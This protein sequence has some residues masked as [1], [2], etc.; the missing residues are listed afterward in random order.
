MDFNKFMDGV[1][2]VMDFVNG[3]PQGT[4]DIYL[5]TENSAA[6]AKKDAILRADLLFKAEKMIENEKDPDKKRLMEIRLGYGV[7]DFSD[8]V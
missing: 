5:H 2:W 4:N 3:T 8:L 1:F 7:T 6:I